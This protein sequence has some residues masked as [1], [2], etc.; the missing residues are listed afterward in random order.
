MG[1]HADHFS[2][3][4]KATETQVILMEAQFDQWV[5]LANWKIWRQASDGP[6]RVSV[7]LVN[8]S[9][10]PIT[11]NE[12]ILIFEKWGTTQA[13]KYRLGQNTFISPTIPHVIEIDPNISA[14]QSDGTVAFSVS[15]HF[16][17]SHRISKQPVI[18]PFSGILECSRWSIDRQW[19]ATF[20]PHIH[21]NPE[22][23]EKTDKAN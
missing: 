20:T 1:T 7:D 16:L 22:P 15:G 2:K 3:L 18:Q 8:L 11:L 13:T 21:M 9:Q 17:H 5:V 19:H 6:L 4:A 10:F 23:A 14:E 12:G